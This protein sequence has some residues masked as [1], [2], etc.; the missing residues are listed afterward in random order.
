MVKV[1]LAWECLQQVRR[2]CPQKPAASLNVIYEG[3]CSA[4]AID[5]IIGNNL[6]IVFVEF[7]P[8]ANVTT[9]TIVID[10]GFR[11]VDYTLFKRDGWVCE[12]VRICLYVECR[13]FPC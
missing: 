7:S 4:L 10:E 6:A 1:F 11:E 9:V 5:S 13:H 3:I 2:M 12:R 8:T